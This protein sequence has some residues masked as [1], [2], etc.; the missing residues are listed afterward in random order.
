MNK[1]GKGESN[2]R[3]KDDRRKKESML[4]MASK[5]CEC[6]A[7]ANRLDPN[8]LKTFKMNNHCQLYH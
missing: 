8:P 3:K 5:A 6:V 2:R 1:G 4:T 7:H